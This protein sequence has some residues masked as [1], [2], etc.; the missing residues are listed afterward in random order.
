MWLAW[1][2]RLRIAVES[3]ELNTYVIAID[4]CRLV[5]LA[6][7]NCWILWVTPAHKEKKKN[8]KESLDFLLDPKY[9]KPIVLAITVVMLFRSIM[10][11]VL[12]DVTRIEDF[13]SGLVESEE[14][15]ICGLIYC[16]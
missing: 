11:L 8:I 7:R 5:T 13:L 12:S 9:I 6:C 10:Y 4:F 16:V 3:R 1:S 15:S 14:K 2:N